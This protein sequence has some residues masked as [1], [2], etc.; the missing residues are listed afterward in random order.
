MATSQTTLQNPNS[1][2]L[3]SAKIEYSTDDGSTFTDL[4]LADN[5]VIT[6][7]STPREVQPGNG[8]TPDIAKGSASQMA[9]VTAE[10][11]E[12]STLNYA[13][14]SGGLFNRTTVA[15]TPLVDEND[16]HVANA[17]AASLFYPFATQQYNAAVPTNI[18]IADSTPQTLVL[19]TDYE[20]VKVGNS[21]GYWF[22]TGGLYDA[23]K[24]I[25][26]EYDVTPSVSEKVTVGG[27][28]SQ[29]PIYVRATN[30]VLR[31]DVAYDIS[32]VWSL[33]NCFIEGDLAIAMK[34]KDETDAVA[35][36]PIT[37]KAI[38]DGDRAVGDQLYNFNRT[39]IAHA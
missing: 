7:N 27:S 35:R 22:L 32:N 14:L 21:W 28:S 12:L 15:G 20:I 17:T 37:L 8:P 9:T 11:W 39:Q 19:N 1:V 4:G 16:V 5:V 2:I 25:T 38:L 36:V 29:T 10:L 18:S 26:V 33:Y 3:E 34:N 23:T 31:E 13:E 6:F 30:L 24:I